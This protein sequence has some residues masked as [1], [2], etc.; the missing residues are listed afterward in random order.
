ML[1]K[2]LNDTFANL[3][4]L[5]KLIIKQISDQRIDQL[6]YGIVTHIPKIFHELNVN[7]YE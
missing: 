4:V 3:S 7:G 6:L 5:D 2:K 1:N